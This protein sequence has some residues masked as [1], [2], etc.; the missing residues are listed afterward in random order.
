MPPFLIPGAIPLLFLFMLLGTPAPVAAQNGTPRTAADSLRRTQDSVLAAANQAIRGDST[1]LDEYQKIIG[2]LKARRH[3]DAELTLG[4]KMIAANPGSALAYFTYGDAQLDN[5]MPDRAIGTLLKA[6]IVEPRF[7]RARVTLAEAYMMMKSYDTALAQL[8]TAIAH[9]PRY[10]QAH[11]Q[12]A[13]VLAQLGRETEAIE[14]YR[15][16]SELLPDSYAH[17][18]KLGRLLL[19]AG[20]PDE[21]TE[22]LEYAVVLNAESSDAHYF[23]AEALARSGRKE[24]AIKAYNAFWMRFPRDRRALDAERAARELGGQ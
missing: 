19:D 3:Y 22:A 14:N 18:L 4:E 15:A 16:V 11:V 23:H 9:N 24:E 5:A 20:Q 13:S 7:V 6:L 17:W 10:A 1:L 8:D 21:A 12:R 2:V